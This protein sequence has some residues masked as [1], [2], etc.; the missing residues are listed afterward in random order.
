M[1]KIE[2]GLK[3]FAMVFD[4]VAQDLQ[5]I[6]DLSHDK[7]KEKMEKLIPSLIKLSKGRSG[8]LREL[9]KKYLLKG[10]LRPKVKASSKPKEKSKPKVKSS[11]NKNSVENN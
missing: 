10:I 3:H 4:V 5:T 6:L 11:L 1:V 9:D 8:E 2:I 7:R